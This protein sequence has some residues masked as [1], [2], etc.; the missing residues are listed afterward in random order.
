MESSPSS[1]LSFFTTSGVLIQSPIEGLECGIAVA[2]PKEREKVA[3]LKLGTLALPLWFAQDSLCALSAWPAC[4]PGQ[5]KVSLECGDIRE[6]RVITVM[7]QHFTENEFF[8]MVHE[9]TDQLPIAIASRLQE[10]GGLAG[11]NLVAIQEMSIEQEYYRLR[12]A[13]R[14][15]KERPG[16]L[17]LLPMIQRDC[18]QVLVPKHELRK[19]NK[20]RR[21][22]ISR[23]PQAMTMPGNVSWDGY[24]NQMFDVTVE[25]SYETYENRLVKAYVQA[26]QSQFSRL[27]SRLESEP[28]QASIT[29]EIQDLFGEF[30]LTC[31]RTGF[32][33]Q[34]RLPFVSAGR[35]TMVLLKKPAYRAVLEDYLALYKR[36][37]V[38][39][40]EPALNTPLNKFPYLYQLWANLKVVKAML[41]VCAEA[42]FRCTSHKWIKRDSKGFF[43]DVMND[44]STAIELTSP[45]TGKTVK[46][47]PW[48]PASGQVATNHRQDLPPALTVCVYTAGKP[49][50]VLVFDPKYKVVGVSPEMAVAKRTAVKAESAEALSSIEPVPEHIDELRSCTEAVRTPGGVREIQYA[51]ILYPG[52]RKQIAAT[53]EA[54]PARPE[55]GEGME[56]LIADVLRP[57]LT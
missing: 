44:C 13:V 40:E 20:T 49:P 56:K 36:A 11:I 26:L 17:Q 54:L 6:R 9:L 47:I 5:Y 53:I 45:T 14:G 12:Q 23:L 41:Q 39:L 32:L 8:Y 52:L 30:R 29:R 15:T 19:V 24:V 2:I 21:P 35:V 38:R 4:G 22:D 27:L 33:R 42:G 7:P 50:V 51:A 1:R 10:C 43:I 48:S 57:H 16:I 34:V 37:P 46:L 55:D 31:S 28:A 3:S 18:Y 25:R